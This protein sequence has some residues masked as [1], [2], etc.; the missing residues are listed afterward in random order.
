[1]KPGREPPLDQR[2]DHVVHDESRAAIAERERLRKGQQHQIVMIHT[3][4]GQRRRARPHAGDDTGELLPDRP[5][6]VRQMIR[7]HQSHEHETLDPPG[8][9]DSQPT[10]GIERGVMQPEAI[11]TIAELRRPALTALHVGGYCRVGAKG[12]PVP[13]RIHQG[14]LGL[15]ASRAAGTELRHQVRHDR[16]RLVPKLV[17]GFLDSSA[18]D[19]GDLGVA[20]QR[21]GDGVFRQAHGA[22]D[23]FKRWSGHGK[24]GGC[25]VFPDSYLTVK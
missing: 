4:E 6:C 18:R 16:V 23:V 9:E 5:Q 14:E 21:Q 7:V 25:P 19:C 10:G 24:Y 15:Q 1:M 8:A 11:K 20:P 22:G 12:L 17:G 3:A 13:V 2:I